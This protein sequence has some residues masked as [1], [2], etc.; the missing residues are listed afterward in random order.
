[1]NSA[2]KRVAGRL[3]DIGRV[4]DLLDAAGVHH[5][6]PIGHDERLALVVR[7]EHRGD[8]EPA[9]DG[10]DLDAHLL[11]QLEIEVRQRLVQQQHGRIDDERAGERHPLPLA[12]RHLQRTALAQAGELARGRARPRRACAISAAGTLR[13]RRPNATLSATLMCGNSA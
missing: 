12:A 10:D 5:R 8:A 9:L 13:I 3:V 7:H 4:A 11:A 2:T 6:D 1:M